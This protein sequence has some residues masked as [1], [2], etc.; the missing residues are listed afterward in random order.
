MERQLDV[1]PLDFRP[2]LTACRACTTGIPIKRLMQNG[3]DK[4][5]RGRTSC[6]CFG[7]RL[8]DEE[9]AGMALACSIVEKLT[10]LIDNKD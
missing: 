3:N 2:L 1:S 10:K 5:N 6:N 9:I 7:E 8:Q 4:I